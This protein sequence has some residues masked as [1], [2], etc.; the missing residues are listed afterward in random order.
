MGWV[1][2]VTDYGRDAFIKERTAN[3]DTSSVSWECI[4]FADKGSRLWKVIRRTVIATGESTTFI[5]LDLIKKARGQ[6]WGYKDM[7]E[8]EG[9]AYYDCPKRLLDLAPLPSDAN[10]YAVEWRKELAE[11]KSAPKAKRLVLEPNMDVVLH[12]WCTVGGVNNL[13]GT[14]LYRRNKVTW[15]AEL[16]SEEHRMIVAHSCPIQ[17]KH[18]KSIKAP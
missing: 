13:T 9:P 8:Y 17:A 6:G 5:A 10:E 11:R 12:E 4:A 1:F 3:E 2:H 7:S 14:L 18:I 15:V 16:R